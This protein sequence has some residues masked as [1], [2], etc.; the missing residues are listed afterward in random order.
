[1]SVF[2]LLFFIFGTILLGTCYTPL[3][4]QQPVFDC[5]VLWQKLQA[6]N[7]FTAADA[8]K[9]EDYF[10]QE[11]CGC[12]HATGDTAKL[13]Q[14]RYVTNLSA[15]S[16]GYALMKTL[17]Y[18]AIVDSDFNEICQ[19]LN[20]T[21]NYIG[22]GYFTEEQFGQIVL[23]NAHGQAIR[24]PQQYQRLKVLASQKTGKT[25]FIGQTGLT[26][27]AFNEEGTI[28]KTWEGISRTEVLSDHLL[29]LYTYTPPVGEYDLGTAKNAIYNADLEELLPLTAGKMNLVDNQFIFVTDK[30]E[31][32]I[33]DAKGNLKLR[34]A[35]VHYRDT[36]N[37]FKMVAQINGRWMNYDLDK[38][39]FDSLVPHPELNRY[40][41]SL[42]VHPKNNKAFIIRN[43]QMKS[44]F[45][46][47]VKQIDQLD[48]NWLGI[49]TEREAFCWNLKTG[50]KIKQ[51]KTYLEAKA[52]KNGETTN[53]NY[54]IFPFLFKTSHIADEKRRIESKHL[55]VY[56]SYAY[57]ATGNATTLIRQDYR[58]NI[59]SA[60]LVIEKGYCFNYN[61]KNQLVDSFPADAVYELH[62]NNLL[63][64]SDHP[65]FIPLAYSHKGK[66]G[67]FYLGNALRTAAIYEEVK[68][69]KNRVF[70]ITIRENGKY[71]VIDP[72]GKVIVP[73]KYAITSFE[74]N[75]TIRTQQVN[76]NG[77]PLVGHFFSLLPLEPVM[78]SSVYFQPSLT[79]R[80]LLKTS[81]KNHKRSCID[82]AN[83][84]INVANTQL[85]FPLHNGNFLASKEDEYHKQLVDQKQQQLVQANLFNYCELP[86]GF[87]FTSNVESL[88]NAVYSNQ[89][90][91][92]IPLDL[93]LTFDET[94]AKQLLGKK[95]GQTYLINSDGSQVKLP[96]GFHYKITNYD[97][98]VYYAKP[99]N[100]SLWGL[101]KSDGTQLTQAIY[102][103]AYDFEG[104]HGI[105]WK[106]MKRY[107]I[108]VD[109]K[110]LGF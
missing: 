51:P 94:N 31:A 95:E 19:T 20:P 88:K 16:G 9:S 53:T 38:G 103:K 93:Q 83:G 27:E 78:D 63:N 104:E 107:Y 17:W 76:E 1:M 102:E 13:N 5:S 12:L 90:K 100:T 2:R 99:D 98:L 22:L 41:Y 84:G 106:Q 40:G 32:L 75:G 86:S 73:P 7:R 82:L 58:W 66:Q 79:Q 80:H 101:M 24:T 45:A 69:D 60:R 85:L 42:V 52:L 23:F 39:V 43:A 26:C 29:L 15:F 71:G 54:S 37:D 36:K 30:S 56:E 67:L 35:G 8:A 57:D 105:V 108:G 92:A 21:A 49:Y 110:I 89:T 4:A 68:A 50:K 10:F 18:F 48:E 96:E 55:F 3:F 87:Y 109:G 33:L 25:L 28:L 72:F 47:P 74:E 91:T 14:F 11:Y 64:F 77:S 44:E 65:E 46:E 70:R 97:G 81:Y 6:S 61:A 34:Q 59:T 62:R